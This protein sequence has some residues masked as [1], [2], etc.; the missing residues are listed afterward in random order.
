MDA[1]EKPEE[2]P[3]IEID[4]PSKRIE[5]VEKELELLKAVIRRQSEMFF[6]LRDWISD[7]NVRIDVYSAKVQDW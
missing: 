7:L 5:E 1:P 3:L 4:V 2:P 6:Q